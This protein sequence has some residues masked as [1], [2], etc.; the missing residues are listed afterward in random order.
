[1]STA[2]DIPARE[3]YLPPLIMSQEFAMESGAVATAARSG[4]E[5][6]AGLSAVKDI[7]FG[8]VSRNLLLRHPH[9]SEWKANGRTVRRNNWK[10]YRIP[11]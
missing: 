6:A 2:P 7:V 11:F 3:F 5:E 9:G 1:M 8:S 10:I 4:E